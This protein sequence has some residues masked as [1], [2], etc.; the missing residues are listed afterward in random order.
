[1]GAYAPP[2]NGGSGGCKPSGR[3]KG[4]AAPPALLPFYPRALVK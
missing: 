1:M 2:M 4:G 3:G